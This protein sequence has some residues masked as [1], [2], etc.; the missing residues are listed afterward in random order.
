M[1][2]FLLSLNPLRLDPEKQKNQ[3][4]AAIAL[5]A[6]LIIGL[7]GV[8]GWT[9]IASAAEIGNGQPAAEQ[10]DRAYSQFSQEAGLQE[11]IFQERLQQGENPDKLPQPYKRIKNLDD[12]EVPETSLVETAVSKTRQAIEDLTGKGKE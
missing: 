6:T 11:E 1:K 8:L 2:Q 10:I 3:P 4:Q 7:A 5:L 9:P 12:R